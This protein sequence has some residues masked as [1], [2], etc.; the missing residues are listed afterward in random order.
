MISASTTADALDLLSHLT[1]HVA[2]C[3]R[4]VVPFF[5]SRLYG[6]DF[7]PL[8]L[9]LKSLYPLWVHKIYLNLVPIM[10]TMF[11]RIL[12]ESERKAIRGYLKK[13]GP[14]EVAVRK[15]VYRA[16]RYLPQIKRDLELL[17]NL[18]E[19]YERTRK[20]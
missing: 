17:E 7:F 2:G 9:H 3:Q 8:S 20:G 13:D 4:L 1:I 16:K 6:E 5:R 14:R 18:L 15:A 10:G 19:T 11:T 12:T